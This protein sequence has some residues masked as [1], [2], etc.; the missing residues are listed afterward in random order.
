MLAEAACARAL[1][2]TWA[3]SASNTGASP[4]GLERA[5]PACELARGDERDCAFKLFGDKLAERITPRSDLGE[6]GA[7]PAVR[8]RDGSSERLAKVGKLLGRDPQFFVA[9]ASDDPSRVS[10]GDIGWNL[11]A[12]NEPSEARVRVVEV[13]RSGDLDRVLLVTHWVED[14]LLRQ[15]RRERAE[16][17]MRD[18]AK[19]VRADGA[20]QG[21]QSRHRIVKVAAE[22]VTR[23]CGGGRSS[24]PRA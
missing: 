5:W 23:R 10:L 24:R 20:P 3:E 15:T 8:D 2:K 4:V 13:P 22:R 12:R 19:L 1:L 18:E 21:G 11:E 7:E 9:A 16:R 14:G 6:A 17:R